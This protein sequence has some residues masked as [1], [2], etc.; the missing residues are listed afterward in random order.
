MEKITQSDILTDAVNQWRRHSDDPSREDRLSDSARAEVFRSVLEG[1]TPGRIRRH[2]RSLFLPGAR[3]AVAS[4]VPVALI[5]GILGFGDFSRVEQP[6]GD[7][8]QQTSPRIS[9]SKEN[10]EV[11]FIIANG[12]TGHRVTRTAA[13]DPTSASAVTTTD[14]TYRDGLTGGPDLVFYRID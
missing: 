1:E 13:D 8:A 5:V 9:V 11:V 7:I 10:G 2:L 6:M 4:A 3:I 12:T 14:G